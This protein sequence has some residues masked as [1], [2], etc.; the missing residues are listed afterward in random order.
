DSLQDSGHRTLLGRHT[1][2]PRQSESDCRDR[3]RA[4]RQRN[5]AVRV[6]VVLDLRDLPRRPRR[7]GGHK[8]GQEN[9]E[10][11]LRP[12]H[13]TP[14]GQPTK[15]RRRRRRRGG[16]K[17]RAERDVQLSERAVLG[18]SGEGRDGDGELDRCGGGSVRRFR[19]REA[20]ARGGGVAAD[21]GAGGLERVSGAWGDWGSVGVEGCEDQRVCFGGAAAEAAE[22]GSEMAKVVATKQCVYWGFFDSFRWFVVGKAL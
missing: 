11:P 10:R 16:F 8:P 5:R 19:R 2:R 20:V 9:G 12:P 14:S 6:G 15:T 1:L 7:P 4:A 18:E 17:R 3:G 13:H 22:V 21:G